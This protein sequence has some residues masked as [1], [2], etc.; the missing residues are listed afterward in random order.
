MYRDELS[1]KNIKGKTLSFVK[2]VAFDNVPNVRV[3]ER[4]KNGMDNK[5]V[6]QFVTSLSD[7][8]F[9]VQE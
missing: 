3:G 1:S 2:K 4:V 6:I 7:V 9:E 8:A 5:N